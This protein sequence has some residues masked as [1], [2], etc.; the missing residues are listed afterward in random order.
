MTL[1]QWDKLSAFIKSEAEYAANEVM[2]R[3]DVSDARRRYEFEDEA[4]NV[5]LS[6]DSE[7][8]ALLD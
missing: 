5:L 3:N 4:R 1:E 7:F 2:N 6:K 8:K